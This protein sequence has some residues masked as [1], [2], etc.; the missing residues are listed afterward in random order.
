MVEL[1]EEFVLDEVEL[2]VPAPHEH[3]VHVV[4]DSGEAIGHVLR[5]SPLHL[6]VPEL[7]VLGAC[8]EQ[9]VFTLARLLGKKNLS[10]GQLSLFR[11]FL[12]Y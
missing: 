12:L 7:P 8:A 4:G 6:S 2:P 3:R 10:T 1:P 11:L 9:T 5:E